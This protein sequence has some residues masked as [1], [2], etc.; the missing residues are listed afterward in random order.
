MR[1]R[2][3]LLKKLLEIN[4]KVG[5]NKI[6][7]A[8]REGGNGRGPNWVKAARLAILGIGVTL[9]EEPMHRAPCP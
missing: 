5:I 2:R 1:P 3:T 6:C 4:P 9:T 8:L 7:K